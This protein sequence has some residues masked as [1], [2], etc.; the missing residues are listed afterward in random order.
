[1]SFFCAIIHIA[2]SFVMLRARPAVYVFPRLL[3]ISLAGWRC[4]QRLAVPAPSL[5]HSCSVIAG[6]TRNLCHSERSKES[7]VRLY[8]PQVSPKAT[9][10]QQ[11]APCSTDFLHISCALPVGAPSY[12]RFGGE[13][14]A[15]GRSVHRN[16]RYCGR[17]RCKLCVCK[18]IFVGLCV[19]AAGILRYVRT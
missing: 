17:W 8:F 7:Y 13:T 1:M 10:S 18:R 2:L 12:G 6:S 3:R 11:K 15:K 19:F 16:T 9:K 4:L 14:L 5:H